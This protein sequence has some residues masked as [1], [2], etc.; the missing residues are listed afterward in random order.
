MIADRVRM[1]A[2]REA[3][4]RAIRPRAVVVD[5][6]AG[7]GIMSLLACKLGA[8]RVYAI[9]PDGVIQVARE[10][11]AANGFGER[12]RF[13]ED[14]STEVTLPERADVVVADLR[15]SLPL[16]QHLPVMI[17]ARSRFLAP[18]G[19]LIPR[20]DDLH[21]AVVSAEHEYACHRRPW[22]DGAPEL[23]MTAAEA[24]ILSTP[25]RARLPESELVTPARVWA[26]IDY[27]VVS[28]R[29][30][31]GRATWTMARP[32]TGRGLRLW[33]DTELVEGVGFS[34]GPGVPETVYGA[35]FFPWRE[36][37]SLAPGDEVTVALQADPVGD[38]YLW[39]WSTTVLTPGAPA[40]KASFR[41]STFDALPL[42]AGWVRRGAPAHVP[43]LA[44]EGRIVSFVLAEMERARPLSAIA[45]AL[46]ER[47]PA[48][49]P[50][51]A[52]ALARVAAL[53]RKY[54]R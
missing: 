31:A 47:F 37:V 35:A 18:A 16:T 7:S 20:R 48:A 50:D 43:R 4:R 32:A 24:R 3:L 27:L 22:R 1:A 9:E 11:A 46:M 23:D 52:T 51:Q 17:D 42:T 45:G 19:V 39:C 29:R 8:A 40:P 34:N 54:G 25:R 44:E 12:V 28:S 6:G 13:F 53:S 14:R 2:H 5:I 41:Q 33:F 36:P 38:R 49:A 26:T 15:N 10:L 21:V 30:V